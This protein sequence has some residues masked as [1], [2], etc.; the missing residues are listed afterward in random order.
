MYGVGDL[1]DFKS[2]YRPLKKEFPEKTFL[3]ILDGDLDDSHSIKDFLRIKDELVQMAEYNTEYF[4]LEKGHILLR[5][6]ESFSD[7]DEFRCYCKKEFL[8][9]KGKDASQMGDMDFAA[10]LGG[11]PK[12]EIVKDYDTL[13]SLINQ[14][15]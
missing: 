2:K 15:I 11:I 5:K 9:T 10:I 8:R 4:L 6:P 1:T 13:F 7:R 12:D 14:N 3:F